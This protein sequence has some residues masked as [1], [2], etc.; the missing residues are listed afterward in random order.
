MS[1]KAL[2]PARSEPSASCR[3]PSFLFL[4]D[5]WA[6]RSQPRASLVTDLAWLLPAVALAM[7]GPSRGS[8]AEDRVGNVMV[9]TL[10][11]H[12]RR[13]YGK[14]VVS[15]TTGELLRHDRV[16]V[17]GALTTNV[18]SIRTACSMGYQPFATVFAVR[19]S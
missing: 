14:A 19:F 5:A 12:R 7:L 13:G 17:W 3:F 18:A 2:G 6:G 9:R 15:T 8:G 1:G 16:G 11:G 4:P 10:E